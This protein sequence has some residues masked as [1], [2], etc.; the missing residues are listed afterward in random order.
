MVIKA[1][2]YLIYLS[3]SIV[4]QKLNIHYLQWKQVHFKYPKAFNG[5]D[6]EICLY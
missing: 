6:S 1:S 3:F 5:K 2:T 4:K